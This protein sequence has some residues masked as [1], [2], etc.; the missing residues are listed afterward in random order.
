MELPSLSLLRIAPVPA[1][2]T[3][4]QVVCTLDGEKK[5]RARVVLRNAAGDRLDTHTLRCSQ[6]G[7]TAVFYPALRDYAL[8]RGLQF[9][10]SQSAS[11]AL[12]P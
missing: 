3:V 7:W 4:L 2:A 6:F 5:V 8:H 11:L 10:A 12:E 9:D 1:G